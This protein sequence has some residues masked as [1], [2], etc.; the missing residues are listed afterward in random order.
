[1]IREVVAEAIAEYGVLRV[2]L[3]LLLAP[4]Y[5]LGLWFLAVAYLVAGGA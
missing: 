5:A 4:F 1:M 2:T 3:A